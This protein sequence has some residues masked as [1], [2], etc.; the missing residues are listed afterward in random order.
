[1]VLY[2]NAS[3]YLV[4]LSFTFF[5]SEICLTFLHLIIIYAKGSYSLS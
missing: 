2:L 4:K 3:K 5:T 1:M